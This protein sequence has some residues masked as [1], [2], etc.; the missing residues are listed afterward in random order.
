MIKLIASD[1]DGTLLPS[2]QKELDKELI[3]IIKELKKNGYAFCVASGR[4][5][6][7]Q[8]R[9]FAEVS[10]DTV[11]CCENGSVIVYNDE[12]QS[13]ICI[14]DAIAEQLIAEISK[15]TDSQVLI[16]GEMTSYMLNPP[17]DFYN[18][19]KYNLQN[20]V[21]WI[22]KQEDIP[23]KI[24]KI[25]IFCKSGAEKYF[26]EFYNRWNSKLNVA[27]AGSQ[28]LD[29]TLGDKGSGL[30]QACRVVGISPDDAVVFG[31]NFNDVP[32]FKVAGK[33]FAM[34]KSDNKVKHQA[35]GVCENINDS[36]KKILNE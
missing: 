16:S 21:K 23:E 33:S 5:Y 22:S 28:W 6:L 10:K 4:Q 12:V 9:L 3:D 30:K 2:G 14:D 34:E 13:K 7:S 25:S 29:F 31:D 35:D 20:N 26:K 27:I 24:V 36:L 15:L 18:F 1:I 8:K 11:F 17:M 19:I 32:M